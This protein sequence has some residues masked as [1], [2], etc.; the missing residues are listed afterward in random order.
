[1]GRASINNPMLKDGWKG[2]NF[3]GNFKTAPK[4]STLEGS[5]TRKQTYYLKKDYGDCLANGIWRSLG[6]RTFLIWGTFHN[7]VKKLY[8][9]FHHLFVSFLYMFI[10][11]SMQHNMSKIFSWQHIERMQYTDMIFL[12]LVDITLRYM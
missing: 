3:Y 7:R 5:S 9:C 1:M 11:F 6:S 8:A 2:S 4:S 10:I 12:C